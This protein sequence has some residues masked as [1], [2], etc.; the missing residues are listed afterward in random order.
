M[1]RLRH[2]APTT[3][4]TYIHWIKHFLAFTS[5]NRNTDITP[6]DVTHFL[7]YLAV[8]RKVAAATQ[9][10][11]LNALVFFYKYT[12][13]VNI[14]NSIDAVRARRRRRLP[15]VLTRSEIDQIFQHLTH[16]K[17][18]AMIM[19]GAG[20]RLSECVNL[21]IKDIDFEN[22]LIIVRS[23]KGDKDRRT[24]LPDSIHTLLLAHREQAHTLFAKDRKAD[25]PGVEL[26][27]ALERKY[28]NAG[29]EWG[30]FWLFP[31]H[32]LSVDPRS[33]ITRRHHIYPAIIQREF[34]QALMK[35]AITKH[36][37]IE[38]ASPL[39]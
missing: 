28:P 11:A 14:E 8:E 7:S 5:K 30:W 23:G 17:L 32:K 2:L 37:I 18:E 15:V 34:K 3:E 33:L 10:Q 4:K 12:L 38:L 25:I 39:C 22:K 1:I 35:T 21:R 9:N 16:H 36:H 26:P 24:M 20:L 19:Y 6:E 29:K 27:N 31:S 13:E